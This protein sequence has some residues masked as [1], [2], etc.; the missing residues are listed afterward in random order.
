MIERVLIACDLDRTLIY[1]RRF[2]DAAGPGSR[3]VEVYEGEEISFMTGN[4][5]TL[6]ADLGAKQVVIPATTRTVAQYRR[7]TLP[8]AP[9]RFA[10][11]SN[12]GTILVDGIPDPEWE[13]VVDAR[14]R[15]EGVPLA[16]I[17]TALRSRTTDRWLRKERVAGGLFCY[18]VVD[19]GAVPTEFV[20]E[21]AA[22]CEQRGWRVS[23]QGRK[24]YTVPRPL[25]KSRAVDEVRRRL[26]ASG[27]LA[28]DAP[29]LAAGD[30][31]LDA[32]LLRYADA[33]IRPAHGELH[34]QGW[35]TEGLAVTVRAGAVA[36]EEILAW[37]RLRAEWSC[38]V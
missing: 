18:I 36:A 5:V 8:G 14:I 11:T 34:A 33:A 37:L 28:T 16:E 24:I 32:E 31:A 30:G 3:C 19:E 7:I 26:V 4:A 1:S 9:Y 38:Q 10:V 20:P 15:A 12:G 23:Q 35:T 6:L 17:L 13:A 29:A 25:C 27:E 21:W 2:L 22:W